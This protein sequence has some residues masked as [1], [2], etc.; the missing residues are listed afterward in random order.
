MRYTIEHTV[1]HKHLNVGLY[2]EKK[3][4]IPSPGRFS[5]RFAL[6]LC[7]VDLFSFLFLSICRLSLFI[8]QIRTAYFTFTKRILRFGRKPN[9]FAGFVFF[10]FAFSSL[11]L[12]Y[13]VFL[14]ED[15]NN[16]GA[17]LIVDDDSRMSLRR[18]SLKDFL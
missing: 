12:C 14:F 15:G 9:A 2:K 1:S 5:T 4:A 11:L 18:A 3:R 8:S 10:L 17:T 6:S 13:F 7:P 16:I